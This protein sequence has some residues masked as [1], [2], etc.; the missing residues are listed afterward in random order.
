MGTLKASSIKNIKDLETKKAYAEY[1]IRA[2]DLDAEFDNWVPNILIA[3]KKAK[4]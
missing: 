2:G 3:I 1:K 4:N